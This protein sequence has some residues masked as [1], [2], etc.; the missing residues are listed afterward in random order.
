MSALPPARLCLPPI[1]PPPRRSPPAPGAR[2][3]RL[4]SRKRG[5]P[6]GELRELMRFEKRAAIPDDGYGNF[7]G[8]WQAAFEHHARIAPM[9]GSEP[10]IAARLTGIQPVKITVRDDSQTRQITAGWRAVAV[11]DGTRIFNITS[12]LAN[13]DERRAYLVFMGQAGIPT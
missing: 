1:P 3:A 10:V 12:P 5:M 2:R 8:D 6:A 4:K 7:E 13:T 9:L 11:H